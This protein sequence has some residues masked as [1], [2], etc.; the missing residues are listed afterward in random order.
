METIFSP[1][2][3]SYFVAETKLYQDRPG[4]RRTTSEAKERQMYM[5]CPLEHIPGNRGY[6]E[7]HIGIRHVFS[8]FSFWLNFCASLSQQ[9]DFFHKAVIYILSVNTQA[10]LKKMITTQSYVLYEHELSVFTFF[11][12]KVFN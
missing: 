10:A 5:P 1:S 8:S 9:R 6:R 2:A 12:C 11:F 4:S 7:L 3:S